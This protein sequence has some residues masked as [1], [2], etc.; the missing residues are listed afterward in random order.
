[1]IPADL[2]EALNLRLKLPQY[3]VMRVLVAAGRPMT[4]AEIAAELG[5][6]T[7]PVYKIMNCL[8][9]KKLVRRSGV[10]RVGG[11]VDR[12]GVTYRVR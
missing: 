4:V 12:G 2:R 1:M 6:G 3:A 11:A 8:Y 5:T 9:R 10:P 7:A